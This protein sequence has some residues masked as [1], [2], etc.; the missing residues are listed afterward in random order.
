[1]P[2]LLCALEK[3]GLAWGLSGCRASL[4]FS[5]LP[6]CAMVILA[7]RSLDGDAVSE[8]SVGPSSCLRLLVEALAGS[9]SE[10]SSSS[11]WLNREA[12]RG[13]MPPQLYILGTCMLS[14]TLPNHDVEWEWNGEETD[15]IAPRI[16]ASTPEHISIRNLHFSRRE[17]GH[18]GHG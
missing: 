14:L 2:V 11:F 16:A 5:T 13:S 17:T 4:W 10:R 6:G 18:S 9:F 3:D 8:T 15:L 7:G 1:M 12:V